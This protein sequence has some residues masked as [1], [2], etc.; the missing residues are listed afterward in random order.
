MDS[1]FA[2][3]G[4]YGNASEL[5]VVDTSSWS[6]DDWDELELACD[7]DRPALAQMITERNESVQN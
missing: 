1:Y 2:K 6:D 3:D 5:I 7:C 4:N